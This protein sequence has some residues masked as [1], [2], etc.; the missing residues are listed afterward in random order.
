MERSLSESPWLAG[1][2]FSLADAALAPL[3][4]RVENLGMKFVWDDF[5]CVRSWIERVKARPSFAQS[6]AP[7]R[8][9]F[10]VPSRESID[11]ARARNF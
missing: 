3:F 11:K 4:E 8:Y 10:P 2:D 9:R 1:E 6:Q 5:A 7:Q